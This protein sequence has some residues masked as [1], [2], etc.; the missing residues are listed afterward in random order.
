MRSKHGADTNAISTRLDALSRSSSSELRIQWRKL[1]GAEAPRYIGRDLLLL[2]LAY[3][4]QEQALGDLGKVTQRRLRIL[5][6]PT[7]PQ[8]AASAAS[9]LSS[10]SR[11]VREWKGQIH[12][13][14]VLEKGYEYLGKRHQSLSEIAGLI[15][16]A[17]WS[18]PRF[19]GL[20]S[21]AVRSSSE[22]RHG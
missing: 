6:D 8:S 18:G 4:I 12:T 5:S 20:K 21:S 10:G 11:L 17:H 16:G 14:L 7:T 9:S 2:A 15:T 3:R 1:C 22:N 19:F 13:V